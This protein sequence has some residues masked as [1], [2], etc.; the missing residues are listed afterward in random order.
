MEDVERL[1]IKQPLHFNLADISSIRMEVLRDKA[2]QTAAAKESRS[3]CKRFWKFSP[4][5]CNPG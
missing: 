3:P 5:N 1:V 2:I 4:W